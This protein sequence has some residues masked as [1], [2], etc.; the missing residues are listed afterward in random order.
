MTGVCRACG[1]R[2]TLTFGLV[3]AHADADITIPGTT[4]RIC[5]GTAKPPKL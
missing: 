1:R 4:A 3:D 2:V 5:K